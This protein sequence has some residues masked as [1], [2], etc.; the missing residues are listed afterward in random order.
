MLWLKTCMWYKPKPLRKKF[1]SGSGSSTYIAAKYLK[2]YLKVMLAN[3]KKF[4]EEAKFN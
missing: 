4:K 2:L 1:C 3:I